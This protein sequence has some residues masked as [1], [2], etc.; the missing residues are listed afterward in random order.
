MHDYLLKTLLWNTT[1]RHTGCSVDYDCWYKNPAKSGTWSIFVLKKKNDSLSK[2]I[3]QVLDFTVSKQASKFLTWHRPL[4]KF[5]THTQL[6]NK[7]CL[8]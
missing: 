1:F 7:P 3:N 6:L 2:K 4:E 8:E 5:G